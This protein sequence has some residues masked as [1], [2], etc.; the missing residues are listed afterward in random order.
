MR[1]LVHVILSRKTR[2]R[3][4]RHIKQEQKNIESTIKFTCTTQQPAAFTWSQASLSSWSA[5]CLCEAAEKSFFPPQTCWDTSGF[6]PIHA[7]P[8]PDLSAHSH[9]A[10]S[11]LIKFALQCVV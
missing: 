5:P 4:K 1:E 10:L 3:S 9:R 11:L 2:L 8:H 7:D 6:I